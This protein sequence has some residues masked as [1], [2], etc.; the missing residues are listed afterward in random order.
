LAVDDVVVAAVPYS[1]RSGAKCSVTGEAEEVIR[2]VFDYFDDAEN[3]MLYWPHCKVSGEEGISYQIE[4]L[5]L[6]ETEDVS[7]HVEQVGLCSVN[8]SVA[9]MEIIER[10]FEQQQ[11]R[12]P[13]NAVFVVLVYDPKIT[14]SAFSLLLKSP[15]PPSEVDRSDLMR[16]SQYAKS[17]NT[18]FNLIMLDVD[19]GLGRELRPLKETAF[20]S[21]GTVLSLEAADIETR[22]DE[23]RRG[24]AR[25]LPGEVTI[26]VERGYARFIDYTVAPERGSLRVVGRCY[27]GDKV[28]IGV[29]IPRL[30][31]RTIRAVRADSSAKDEWTRLRL[32]KLND[33][34]ELLQESDYA[35]S[36]LEHIER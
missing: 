14:P 30:N 17:R 20:S 5:R 1:S 34:F 15:K 4:Q 3:A 27:P 11:A 6:D 18:A 9:C 35:Q 36:E 26:N 16:F 8:G 24:I 12:S 19:P 33:S 28:E 31:L 2:R 10:C 29:E 22:S 21:G 23:I 25:R 32:W 7:E 13:G